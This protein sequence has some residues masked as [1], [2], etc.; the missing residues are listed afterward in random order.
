M[1]KTCSDLFIS[2]Y[3]EGPAQNNAIEVYNPTNNLL[4][5]LAGY[6]INRY[7]NGATSGPHVWPL[8]GVLIAAGEANCSW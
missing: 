5:T 1:L 2:E 6:T 7:A 3:V 4:L 8:S